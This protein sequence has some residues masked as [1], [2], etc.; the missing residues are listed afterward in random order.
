MSYYDRY[1]VKENSFHNEVKDGEVVGFCFQIHIAQYRGIWVSLIR[2]Y[3]VEVDGIAYPLEAQT[4]EIN[5]KNRTYAELA[6]ACW[7]I[8][9][10]KDYATI[11]VACPGGLKPGIHHMKLIQ[12][13]LNAY[14]WQPTDEEYAKNCPRPEEMVGMM[15][16]KLTEYTF[17]LNLT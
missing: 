12:G 17:D 9:N 15:G 10:Y 1:L 16:R 7:E 8:W 4:F 5:G 6:T 3:Y 11:H 2:G 13:T 14:G